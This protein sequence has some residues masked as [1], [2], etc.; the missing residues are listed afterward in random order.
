MT[1]A[2]DKP[3]PTAVR[4][5]NRLLFDDGS[6]L[7]GPL[8]KSRQDGDDLIIEVSFDV[9]GG[10]IAEKMAQALKEKGPEVVADLPDVEI[11]K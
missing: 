6:M 10:G 11:I 8:V 2:A 7:I 3:K 4:F 9:H 1:D 5:G